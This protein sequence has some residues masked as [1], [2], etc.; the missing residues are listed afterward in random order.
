MKSHGAE[1]VA[2]ILSVVCLSIALIN[3]PAFALKQGE[4]TEQVYST[5]LTE[6]TGIVRI[7]VVVFGGFISLLGVYVSLKSVSGKADVAISLDKNRK[8][9]FKRISQ[10]VVITVVGAIVLIAAIYLLPTK[11]SEMKI[12]GTDITIEE[13]NGRHIVHGK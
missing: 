4:V 12:N 3:S 6:A 5:G 10:G 7:I 13:G 11:R 9:N 1:S 8:I 2:V